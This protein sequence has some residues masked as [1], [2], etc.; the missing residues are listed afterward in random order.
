M[1][2]VSDVDTFLDGIRAS[3]RPSFETLSVADARSFYRAGR[4]TVN[5]PPVDV[6]AVLDDSF[7]GR[8]GPVKVRRYLPPGTAHGAQPAILF[9]HGGGWVIGDLDTHDSICRHVV[10]ASG[11]QVIA[12]DY[13]LAPEHRFPA[14]VE[15]AIDAHATMVDRAADWGADPRR[16]ALMG[17]S[18]GG[19]LAMVV[20]MHARDMCLPLPV[21]QA[22]F[23]PVAD[24]RGQTESYARIAD[25]P[26]TARTM[27]WFRDHYLEHGDQAADWRCSPLLARSYASLP[28]S[29][30]T[31]CGRDPLYDEGKALAARLYRKGITVSLR[32]LPDQIHGYLTLGRALGEARQSIDAA[33]A[34]IRRH[35]A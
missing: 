14:A 3:G 5:L 26:I 19:A 6:G 32:D 24:L 18:A 28:P 16:I 25:V 8:G 7:G 27:A 34:F 2:V 22:L 17:D 31:I 29:F 15:D 12:V 33:A 23:Y 1:T 11:L 4:D 35:T 13:R 20:A 30:I 9:F 21:A 10:A